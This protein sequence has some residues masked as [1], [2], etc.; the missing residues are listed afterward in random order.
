[1]VAQGEEHEVVAEI[2]LPEEL[3]GIL[4]V[5]GEAH[6]ARQTVAINLH[7]AA[8]DALQRHLSLTAVYEL[9]LRSRTAVVGTG[10]VEQAVRVADSRPSVGLV[11]DAEGL[12]VG[13]VLAAVGAGLLDG[14]VIE[15][16]IAALLTFYIKGEERVARA[17]EGNELV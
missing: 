13:D 12:A 4:L 8:V 3:L 7:V 1:M 5:V 10:V 16:G 2:I 17:L 14:E 6:V 11:D 9:E 15:L